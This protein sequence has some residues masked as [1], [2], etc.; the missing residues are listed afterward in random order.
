MNLQKILFVIFTLFVFNISFCQNNNN[1]QEK[2]KT[3]ETLGFNITVPE[4]WK[5][6][7]LIGLDSFVGEFIGTN[8]HLKFDMSTNGY[9]SNLNGYKKDLK[10]YT[11]EFDTIGDYA[12]KIIIPKNNNSKNIIG[13]YIS[14]I[15]SKFDFKIS[16]Y[17]LDINQVKTIIT[18]FKSIEITI[19]Q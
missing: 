8:I 18:A 2:L 7:R 14:N 16:G 13:M 10:N 3:I 19:D 9:A 4:T 15:T 11:V 17:N 1:Y 6:N 5:Y 12:R